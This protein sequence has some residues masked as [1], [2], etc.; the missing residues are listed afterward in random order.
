M[1]SGTIPWME[2]TKEIPIA[3]ELRKKNLIKCIAT[4]FTN[5]VTG[6]YYKVVE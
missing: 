6:T 2:E 3:S 5:E 4:N 1:A